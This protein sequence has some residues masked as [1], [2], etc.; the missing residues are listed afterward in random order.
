MKAFLSLDLT[1][2]AALA[3]NLLLPLTMV[4]LLALIAAR[5]VFRRDP[6]ARYVVCLA[7]LL[8][9]LLSPLVVCILHKMGYCLLTLS[10][11]EHFALSP[12]PEAGLPSPLT[13]ELG[14]RASVDTTGLPQPWLAWGVGALLSVWL[15]GVAWGTVHFAR[16]WKEALRLTRGI[17][18]WNAPSQTQT[19]AQLQGVLGR[20]LPPV[21]TSPRVVSP[22]AIGLFRPAV[23][24]P[25]GL[26]ERLS[27]VQLR[28]V[29]LHESAHVAFRHTF[30]GVIER[31]VRLLLWPHPL[32]QALCGELARA[33]E[34]VCDN[35]ASQEDGAACY[36]RTLLAMAQ[37][38][39]TAPHVTSALALLGP[40]T[41]LEERITGLLD[42][43]RNRMVGL[44]RG[45]L[46][47]VTGAAVIA[48]GSTALVRVVAAEKEDTSAGSISVTAPGTGNV[49]VVAPAKAKR[50]S[51]SA[52]GIA[53]SSIAAKPK[54]KTAKQ[55]TAKASAVGTI[56]VGGKV[57][58]RA[59]QAEDPEGDVQEHEIHVEVEP[60]M[61]TELDPETGDPVLHVE[62][63]GVPLPDGEQNFLVTQ[64]AKSSAK[65]AKSSVLTVKAPTQASPAGAR[66]VVRKASA[67]RDTKPII[68]RSRVPGVDTAG[69]GQVREIR[70]NAS[71][72]VDRIDVKERQQRRS[73]I[74]PSPALSRSKDG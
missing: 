41:S 52:S 17:R 66:T 50:S 57:K 46:W 51:V 44:K 30:G 71:G 14:T 6:S 74:P 20:P 40:G 23:I 54:S 58:A 68:V 62:V 39:F 37:G 22:V 15:A 2:L 73:V 7:G 70:V 48:L 27:P 72:R 3:L 53:T 18:P 67:K 59:V 45:K 49:S 1:A 31:V 28:Q 24:L 42:P 34:E 8:S 33:R 9:V 11:P 35:V 12:I 26:T 16:G 29:L 13:A 38:H 10:L 32:V 21:F 55:A 47:A 5:G 60:N 4:C 36:A 65:H 56:T 63:E 69:K 61:H 19:L 43:R 25:E 64:K